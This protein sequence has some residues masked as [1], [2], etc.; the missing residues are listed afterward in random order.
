MRTSSWTQRDARL[1]AASCVVTAGI[2]MGTYYPLTLLARLEADSGL[3]WKSWESTSAL[4]VGSSLEILGL[5]LGGPLA[6]YYPGSALL[7][8]NAAVVMGGMAAFSQSN[9]TGFMLASV[10]VVSFA[11]GLMWPSLGA[12]ISANMPSSKLD[13]SFL[14][15][16]CASRLGDIVGELVLGQLAVHGFSWQESVLILLAV[17]SVLFLNAYLF[18]R[19]CHVEFTGQSTPGIRVTLTK[20]VSFVW[21]PDSWLASLQLSSTELVWSLTAYI[22]VILRDAY[23]ATPEEATKLSVC[24][25]F[26]MLTGLVTTCLLSHLLSIWTG[27]AVQLVQLVIS[28]W[29][30][31]M[32]AKP[33]NLTLH[34]AVFGYFLIGFGFAASYYLP[35]LLYSANSPAEERAFRVGV[36]ES[37]GNLICTVGVWQFGS[38]RTQL[39]TAAALPEIHFMVAMASIATFVC[40]AAMYS[41]FDGRS[42]STG[43][44]ML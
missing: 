6:D 40:T 15:L 23:G 35:H 1:L 17:V 4:T 21:C 44:M 19:G 25:D 37:L 30:L 34:L 38:L 11:K 8:L 24:A 7:G 43:T 3:G 14:L 16:A 18:I 36:I 12:I 32:L 29:A 9:S 22:T 27:R 2:V 42:K 10:C 28:F 13:V 26:G 31:V 5:L 41:R 33:Q 39:G 20:F